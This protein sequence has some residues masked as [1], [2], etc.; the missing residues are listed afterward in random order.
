[1]KHEFEL[2]EELPEKEHK[3]QKPINEEYLALAEALR[4]NTGGWA[5]FPKQY[6]TSGAAS[7]TQYRIRQG[8]LAAFRPAGH[9]DAVVRQGVLYVRHVG[10]LGPSEKE[11]Q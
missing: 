5:P 11:A 9:F 10:D 4:Q 1:M 3:K 6:K 2:F 8:M 7:N